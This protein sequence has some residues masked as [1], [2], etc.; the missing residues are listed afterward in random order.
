M[1]QRV[2]IILTDDIDGSP[3]VETLS[4]ALDGVNYEIDLSEANAAKLREAAQP[5]IAVARKTSGR[6][7]AGRRRTVG[8]TSATEIREWALS[9][10][11]Q[12]SARGRVSAEV[13]AAYEA[14]H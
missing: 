1:A 8:G 6:A 3:A 12:V 7:R 2:S 9:Q 10:G 14:A 5:F 11:M 4:F 13:R